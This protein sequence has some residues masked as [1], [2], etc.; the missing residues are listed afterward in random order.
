MRAANAH[1]SSAAASDPHVPGPGRNR[2]TAKN[3]A[4]SVAQR[5]VAVF[6]RLSV[7]LFDRGIVVAGIVGFGIVQRCGYDVASAGPLAQV[8]QAAA[9]T[10]KRELWAA[11]Q[12]E[13]FAGR[14]SQGFATLLRHSLL[15]RCARPSRSRVPR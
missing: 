13:L 14:A 6:D 8:D 7:R 5:G 9:L 11:G 10:A 2:P 1:H 15:I 3:V 4:T 12:R